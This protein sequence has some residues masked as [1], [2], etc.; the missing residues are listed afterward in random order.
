[1][2]LLLILLTL[3]AE[4]PRLTRAERE[5]LRIAA[6]LIDGLVLDINIARLENGVLPVVQDAR[7]DKAAGLQ[8]E[9]LK[10]AATKNI[11]TGDHVCST[12]WLLAHHPELEWWRLLATYGGVLPDWLGSFDLGRLCGYPFSNGSVKDIGYFGGHKSDQVYGWLNSQFG[13]RETLLWV[14]AE[15]VGVASAGVQ[16]GNFVTFA[17]FGWEE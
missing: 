1:M 12:A 15:D 9:W 8:T 14:E 7:L 5:E 13:H 3:T 17:F 2:T 11:P 16:G 6:E 10:Y 4:P